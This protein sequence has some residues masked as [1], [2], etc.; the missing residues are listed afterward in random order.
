MIRFVVNFLNLNLNLNV[1]S[2]VKG[3]AD[4]M[5]TISA[6]IT[7]K[8]QYIDTVVIY[9]DKRHYNGNF[10]LSTFM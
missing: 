9:F 6:D 1:R 7:N 3:S 5:E 10:G 2:S 8:V 4:K